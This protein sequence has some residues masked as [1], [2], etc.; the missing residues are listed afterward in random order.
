[1]CDDTGDVANWRAITTAAIVVTSVC[2]S[3]TATPQSTRMSPSTW[4]LAAA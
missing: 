3:D 2:L 4:G 1:M